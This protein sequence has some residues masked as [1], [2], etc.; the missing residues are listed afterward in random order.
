MH[1]PSVTTLKYFLTHRICRGRLKNLTLLLALMPF[2]AFGLDFTMIANPD[3]VSPNGQ[4]DIQL[5]VTNDSS[6]TETNL[7]VDLGY[8]TGFNNLLEGAILGPL[9]PEDSCNSAGALTTC[10]ATET[11]R[12]DVGSLATGQSEILRL[13]PTVSA[14]RTEDISLTAAVSDEFNTLET[15]SETVNIDADPVLSLTVMED[16][17]P[18]ASGDTLTYTLRYGNL[19]DANV[20]SSSLSLSLPSGT[21]FVSATGNGTMSDNVVSWNLATLAVGAVAQQQVKVTVND[22]L[23]N[24]VQLPVFASITGTHDFETTTRQA[25]SYTAIGSTPL[26]IQLQINPVSARPSE[27]VNLEITV[28]NPTASNITG[29]TVEMVQPIG[30]SNL[31]ES[32]IIGPFTPDTSCNSAGAITT[33][34]PGEP[35]IWTLGTV[36]AGQTVIMSLPATAVAASN[37]GRTIPFAA[38]LN[39]DSG[40]TSIARETLIIDSAPELTLAIEENKFPVTAGDTLTYTIKYGNRSDANV[41]QSNLNFELPAGSEF[42]SATNSGLHQNGVVS[43]DLGT[44]AVNHVAEQQV[45]VS[46][47]AGLT[48]GNQLTSAA[49]IAGISDFNPTER[50]ATSN[51]VVD[52]NPIEIELQV[53]PASAK[54]GEEVITQILVSNT[55]QSVISGASVRMIHPIGLNNISEASVLGPFDTD[56]SC[57]SSGAITTCQQTEPLIWQLGNMAPG[58][59]IALSFP[60]V[61][62]ASSSN[63]RVIPFEAF[64]FDDAGNTAKSTDTLIID[65]DPEVSLSLQADKN[66][67]A[68][69]DTTTYRLKYGNLSDGNVT[70]SLLNFEL[71]VGASFESTTGNGEFSDGVVSWDLGNFAV[72]SVDQQEVVVSVSP[73]LVAGTHLEAEASIEGISD[74]NP[75]ERRATTNTI[76][77]TESF[78]LDIQLDKLSVG[79][80]SPV[81]AEFLFSNT[82]NSPITGASVQFLFPTGLNN[83]A[84]GSVTG[85]FDTATSCDSNG[86]ITT[87]QAT[88]QLNWNLGTVAPGQAVV[89]RLPVFPTASSGSGRVIPFTATAT[90]DSGA[91]VIAKEVL[92]VDSAPELSITLEQDKFPVA[93][94][95]L[96]TYTVSYGNLS[97]DNVTGSSLSV[98]LPENVTFVSASGGGNHSV[99]KVSWD[100]GNFVVGSVAQQKIVVSVNPDVPAGTQLPAWAEINGTSNFNATERRSE[101]NTVVGQASLDI[102]MQI[103]SVPVRGSEQVGLQMLVTNQSAANV[104]GATVTL[105]YPNGLTNV[106]EGAVTGPLDTATSCNSSGAIST[107]QATEIMNW[108]LGTLTPGQSSVITFNTEPVNSNITGSIIPFI[109]V[110]TND[111]GETVV[112]IDSIIVDQASDLTLSMIADKD[113]VAP[114]ELLTYTLRYGN[115]TLNNVSNNQLMFPIPEGTELISISPDGTQSDG[116]VSWDLGLLSNGEVGE[117]KVRVRVNANQANGVQIP[118]KAS[119]LGESNTGPSTQYANAI[120]AVNSSKA[121]EVSLN[122]TPLPALASQET[123]VEITVANTSGSTITAAQLQMIYSEQ[124]SN[125]DE[126]EIVGP[127]D[128]ANSCSSSGAVNTCQAY[129]VLTWELGNL[130]PNQVVTASLPPV[131]SGS[132]A[133]GNII[134]WLAVARADGGLTAWQTNALPIGVGDD[135]DGDGL[136][137]VFDNCP[138]IANA[139][140]AN[141]ELDELGDVCDP[142]DDNDTMLDAWEITYNLDPFDPSDAGL[143][144]DTDNLTNVEEHAAGTIPTDP[145]T[146]DDGLLDGEDPDPTV[147]NLPTAEAGDADSVIE[148]RSYQLDGSAS[149]D[150]VAALWTQSGDVTASLDDATIIDPSFVAPE[151][152]AN[153]VVTFTLRVSGGENTDTDT[154]EIT[155]TPDAN[156]NADA[157]V[158]QNMVVAGT[159]VTLNGASSS[160]DYDSGTLFYSWRQTAGDIDID[161]SN[162]NIAQPTYA[163]PVLSGCLTFELTVMDRLEQTDSDSVII[164]HDEGRPEANAGPDANASVDTQVCLDGS[165]SFDPNGSVVEY[166][167]EETPA[168]TVDLDSAS[169]ATPCFTAPSTADLL[170]FQLTVTDNDGLIDD[171]LVI[172][173][174]GEIPAPNCS[175]G[176]DQQVPETDSGSPVTVSV[177]GSSSSISEGSITSYL[178]SQTAGPDITLENANSVAASFTA[179]AVGPAG[180]TIELAL[181]CTSDRGVATQDRVLI[182]IGDVNIA[183]EANAGNDQTGSEGTGI[184]LDGTASSDPDGNPITYVWSVMSTTGPSVT[185]DDPT[186][187]A[188]SFTAPAVGPE[189]ASITLRLVVTDS[190]GASD[191]DEVVVNITNVNQPPV[192]DIED[193][194]DSNARSNV[195][196]DGTGSS[197]PDGDSLSFAWSQTS[198]TQ[199]ALTG[200]STSTPAFVAP[201][202]D[203][204]LDLGFELTV[205]DGNLTGTAQEI[206]TVTGDPVGPQA[207]VSNDELGAQ[208]YN[209]G[210]GENIVLGFAINTDGTGTELRGLTLQ[211]AG[212]ADDT[213][214]IGTVTLY[215]DVNGDGIAQAEEEIAEGT[216][217]QDDGELEF[218]FTNALILPAGASHF[219][220]TYDL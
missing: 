94:S 154:V 106:N 206:V 137:G 193:V 20:T 132:I 8:P 66:P 174:V 159:S 128:A 166:L 85:P 186:L 40:F 31:I 213:S 152:D 17:N 12:W 173:N 163:A 196:L 117:K 157:G 192:A 11:I 216:Y 171:D 56:V 129:E 111:T 86:A 21:T 182:Q 3:P 197:D 105:L 69:S 77:T 79:P 109:A 218:N 133:N 203:A 6:S 1:A 82:S 118:A 167:W 43:W 217:S 144:G 148:G 89:M 202:T 80:N 15:A 98:D 27:N 107:C 64:F 48:D 138:G 34:Q 88:E 201:D 28:T 33:C 178:W 172:I 113:L 150:Y 76:V 125:L 95:E 208:D 32:S 84:E 45:T 204:D 29:A 30:M 36:P 103:D 2:S 141:N 63:G 59:T 124:L 114:G 160:D 16:E 189:G 145:D 57:N 67:V 115:R 54:A 55:S 194:A 42:V 26:D 73:D 119:I 41:T 78:D 9:S 4:V 62:I 136:G 161:L 112:S 70:S 44:L 220:V 200:G 108:N 13:M 93:S 104:T 135:P 72:G 110:L 120:S 51:T 168:S 176:V 92:V 96:L 191:D 61:A 215:H 169:S 149:T 49:A 121:L 183:P 10:Q 102:E 187:A 181:T 87:C 23:N 147:P 83:V 130:A 210:S 156:P 35:I 198:G 214:N 18:V 65:S 24:G 50:R 19:S 39:D 99:G 207:T 97:N 212:T 211:A 60:G 165:N 162:N 142:D 155:L 46:V 123:F 91:L 127:F 177:D 74:F 175:A 219:I 199:V 139:N 53:N 68:A 81:Q 184:T 185:L 52:T 158:D 140:Q 205:S 151:V 5:I 190:E 22:S 71:P 170:T 179:P 25:S 180:S 134:D 101:S 7:V 90:D 209:A 37:N 195:S 58:Q 164:C 146:D 153:T 100:L 116:V 143:D 122:V 75:T 131:V 14:S 38:V 126:T 188:P 47:G